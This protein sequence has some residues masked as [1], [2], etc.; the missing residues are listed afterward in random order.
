PYGFSRHFRERVLSKLEA[1]IPNETLSKYI[2]NYPAKIKVLA[3]RNE[4]Q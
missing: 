2:N 3:I 1:R 4:R